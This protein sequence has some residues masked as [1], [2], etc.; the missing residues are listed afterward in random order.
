MKKSNPKHFFSL[1]LIAVLIVSIV[2]GCAK[3][4]GA[5]DGEEKN[6][7][8]V[9]VD[10]GGNETTFDITT[11]RGIVGDALQDEGLIEGSNDQYGFFVTKVNGMEAIY[12]KDKTYWSFYINGEYAATG[13]DKTPIEAGSTYMFKVEGE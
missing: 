11:K 6:F 12:E 2:S 3:T 5:E 13:V 1:I 10:K 9:V 8:L 7:S 4:Q